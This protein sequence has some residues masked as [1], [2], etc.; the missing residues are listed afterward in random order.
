MSHYGNIIGNK[1]SNFNDILKEEYEPENY[2][3]KNDE[4]DKEKLSNNI[5]IN[6]DNIINNYG[7]GY[8]TI[9]IIINSILLFIASSYIIYHLSVFN[10]ILSS[11]SKISKNTLGVLGTLAYTMKILG[12]FFSG[13]LLKI[14][15]RKT[16]ILISITST[17][18][19]NIL[20][21]INLSPVTYTIFIL[22]GSYF[23]GNID[24]INIDILCESLPIRLR[25]FF[26]C[27]SYTGFALSSFMQFFFIW[28]LTKKDSNETNMNLVILINSIII[29][30]IGIF[31]YF[32]FDDSVRNL[33][34]KKENEEAFKSLEKYYDKE[35]T[36]LKKE[37][38]D[39]IIK[40]VLKS[41]EII[42]EEG[43]NEIFK[44]NY[45][46]ITIIFIIMNI[47][48]NSYVDGNSFISNDITIENIPKANESSISK[49][50]MVN[51]FFQLFAYVLAGTLAELPLIGRKYGL[52]ICGIFTGLFSFIYLV[53]RENFIIWI[54]FGQLFGNAYVALS[55]SFA[56]ETYPTKVRDIGQG[57][58]NSMA[59]LGS[60]IG[61][62]SYNE[63][64]TIHKSKTTMIIGI[65]S[66]L[67]MAF[68]MCFVRGE[69]KNK[70]LDSNMEEKVSNE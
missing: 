18:F 42:Q 37:E 16:L 63:I 44:G 5:D 20:I 7:Y 10:F 33:I 64:Y 70:P 62:I 23:S 69:T 36:Y 51:Y 67:L 48:S 9:L 17:L 31:T 49:Y 13:F 57:F 6:L 65:I 28:C 34:I 21:N 45:L 12:C 38:K 58:I 22:V 54:G 68:V 2:L 26:I 52:L 46:Q 61:Q 35:K 50:G 11:Q 59:N 47:L 24:P 25:G 56:S 4:N 60:L 27:L 8:R 43:L 53:N 66:S 55:I 41:N 14:M 19:M 30:L 32:I 15:K 3:I 40:Q 1:D 39:F 29:I